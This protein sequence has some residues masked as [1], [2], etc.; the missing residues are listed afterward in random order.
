MK[1]EEYRGYN[2]I[3]TLGVGLY[4]VKAKGQGRTPKGLV[5]SYTSVG[6]ARASIDKH[7]QSLSKKGG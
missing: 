3:N 6:D 5:G 2:I 4:G 7:Y 1:I